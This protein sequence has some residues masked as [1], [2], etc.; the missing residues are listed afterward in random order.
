MLAA[1]CSLDMYRSARILLNA[2]RLA[3]GTGV[4]A[5]FLSTPQWLGSDIGRE[6]MGTP[7][8]DPTRNNY[9]LFKSLVGLS[10]GLRMV[11]A[12]P[13]VDLDE[14]LKVSGAM[15]HVRPLIGI[16]KKNYRKVAGLVHH[17][18]LDMLVN[19]HAWRGHTAEAVHLIN[20]AGIEHRSVEQRQR[21][22]SLAISFGHHTTCLALVRETRPR[23]DQPFYDLLVRAVLRDGRADV[24]KICWGALGNTPLGALV[25]EARR[26][27]RVAAGMD[28]NAVAA[29]L[30]LFIFKM[31]VCIAV[32]RKARLLRGHRRLIELALRH[33]TW[34]ICNRI[35]PDISDRILEQS[36]AAMSLDN[37]Q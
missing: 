25:E 32:F 17:L 37:V 15:P 9:E 3:S 23:I 36:W 4:N 27:E 18:D 11:I 24:V 26:V 16:L 7:C 12:H 2:G 10:S 28:P 13:R 30:D 5:A 22:L 8:F 6:L 35:L 1:A 21:T 34:T 20:V 33:Y 19:Y 31:K 14:L 29:F